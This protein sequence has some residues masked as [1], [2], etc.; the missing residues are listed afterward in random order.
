MIAASKDP[1]MQFPNAEFKVRQIL[2][3]GDFVAVYTNMLN[4][5]SK[6]SE[7]GLRQIHLFRFKDGKI[8]GYWDVTQMIMLNMSNASGAF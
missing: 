7:G 2:A 6:P 5:K 8:V 3:D 4:N 1:A